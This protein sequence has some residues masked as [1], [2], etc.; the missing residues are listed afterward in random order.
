MIRVRISFVWV[1]LLTAATTGCDNTGV[2]SLGE[3]GK[4]DRKEIKGEPSPPLAMN[5]A[6]RLLKEGNERYNLVM[7]GG[8]GASAPFEDNQMRFVALGADMNSEEK[9]RAYLQD[10]YTADAISRIIEYMRID[11]VQGRYVME[12][13]EPFNL[14]DFS[15]VQ[16]LDSVFADGPHRSYRTIARYEDKPREITIQYKYEGGR[17]L[18]EVAAGEFISE[19]SPVNLNMTPEELLQM[20]AEL[21]AELNKMKG[22]LGEDLQEDTLLVP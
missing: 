5:E 6:L 20:Q 13:P 19:D 21:N 17:W 8:T 15:G 4:V 1:I 10:I 18:L 2:D 22:E 3:L 16:K 11:V 9:V 14:V 12:A 7:K